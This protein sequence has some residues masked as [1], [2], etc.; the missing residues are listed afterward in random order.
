MRK[1]NSEAETLTPTEIAEALARP[2]DFGYMGGNPE[3]FHTW[4]LGPVILTRDSRLLD[5][6]NARVLKKRLEESPEWADDYTIASAGHWAVGW[7]EHLSYRV[8]DSDGKP[9]AIAKFLKA[10]DK[11][12]RDYPIADESDYSELESEAEWENVMEVTRQMLANHDGPELTDKIVS[13]VLQWLNEAYPSGLENLDDQ[14]FYPS[15][16]DVTEA[17]QTLEYIKAE[18]E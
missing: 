12:L 8:V 13:D 10:W 3:M 7:V 1:L 4:S 14:G 9:T 2:R 18:E 16:E 17:L 6:S 15:D 5:Q 11:A